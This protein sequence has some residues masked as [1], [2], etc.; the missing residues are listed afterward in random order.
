MHDAFEQVP[1]L[2]KLPLQI[3]CLAAWGELRGRGAEAGS[4]RKLFRPFT[5]LGKWTGIWLYEHG[6]DA[7]R[8][9]PGM[10]EGIVL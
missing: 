1:I 8:K 4:A 9:T 7:V 6:S 2:E 5:R 3:D 10:R